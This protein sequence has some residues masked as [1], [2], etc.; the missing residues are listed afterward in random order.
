MV[1]PRGHKT[2][3]LGWRKALEFVLLIC[4]LCFYKCQLLLFYNVHI[5][6][7]VHVLITIINK[8]AVHIMRV[9]AQK[10]L[11]IGKYDQ[12]YLKVIIFENRIQVGLII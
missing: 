7:V 6:S 1:H 12:K 8:Y 10:F 11:P 3:L 9:Y 5:S 4:L 2:N